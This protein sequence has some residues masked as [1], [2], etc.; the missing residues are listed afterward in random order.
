MATQATKVEEKIYTCSELVNSLHVSER[1][2][3]LINKKYSTLTKTLS[4]WKA[5]LISGNV[6]TK[7]NYP[8][9][10]IEQPKEEVK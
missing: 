2:A 3:F 1:I 4:E 9:I 7:E 5:L 6:F 8:S 10:V